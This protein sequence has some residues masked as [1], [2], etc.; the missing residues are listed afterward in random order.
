[1]KI[2]L[3][4]SEQYDRIRRSLIENNFGTNKFV[5]EAKV[6]GKNN[7]LWAPPV[8]NNSDDLSYGP[9]AANKLMEDASTLIGAPARLLNSVQEH[10]LISLVCITIILVCI[11]AIYCIIQY[12][13]CCG[14]MSLPKRSLP[15]RSPNR[16]EEARAMY[17]NDDYN[18]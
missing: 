2:L 10:W 13:G 14:R 3:T 9:K 5:Y 18:W 16:K 7:V 8:K 17:E 15:R 1:M 11:L 6:S 4:M 12:H